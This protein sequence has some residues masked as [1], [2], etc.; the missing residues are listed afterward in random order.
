MLSYCRKLLQCCQDTKK[1][2]SERATAKFVGGARLEMEGSRFYSC[3][4]HLLPLELSVG[5][6]RAQKWK[7]SA[8]SNY[9]DNE[10]WRIL[11][12]WY[13]QV[14]GGGGQGGGGGFIELKERDEL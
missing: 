12:R 4:V 14:I 7:T 6:Y 11:S 5:A 10:K 13:L 3:K 1:H 2:G 8:W 9:S